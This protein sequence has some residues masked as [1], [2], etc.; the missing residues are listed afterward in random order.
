MKLE[1]GSRSF[2]IFELFGLLAA[3][4][5]TAGSV[6]PWVRIWGVGF[7]GDDVEITYYYGTSGDG[8]VTLALGLLAT[9]MILWR[10]FR[11]RSTTLSTIVLSATIVV[12]IISSLVGVFNWSELHRIP[13]FGRVADYFQ[14]GFQPGWGLVLMT[15]AGF[16]GAAGLVYQMRND[17]FR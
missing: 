9:I 3:V 13:G 1:V 15:F 16:I 14:Y 17:H 10:L 12:L 5:V 8:Q 4:L 6:L 2:S 11:R 7:V